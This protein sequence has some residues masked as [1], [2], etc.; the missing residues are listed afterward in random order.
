MSI[1]NRIKQWLNPPKPKKIA[2]TA[3]VKCLQCGTVSTG[4]FNCVIGRQRYFHK[5]PLR[6]CGQWMT[7]EIEV[8]NEK[9]PVLPGAV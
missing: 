9:A 8:L 1:I 6:W 2:K 5:C 4:N 7:V 3:K